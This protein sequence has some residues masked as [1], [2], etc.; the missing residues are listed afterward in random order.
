M[1]SPKLKLTCGYPQTDPASWSPQKGCGVTTHT[2][3]IYITR[4]SAKQGAAKTHVIA[5]AFPII[6]LILSGLFI[7][8]QSKGADL[9]INTRASQLINPG[10]A[11]VRRLGIKIEDKTRS[12]PRHGL[13]AGANSRKMDVHIWYPGG[14]A[15]PGPLIVFSH[16]FSSNNA[17]CK[18]LARQ[19][20]SLG[21][22][23]AAPNFPATNWM[24]RGGSYIRDAVNQPA[25]LRFLID[26]LLAW[27]IIQEN[28]LAGRIDPVRIGAM[29]V[30]LG[31][32]TTT[33]LAF[34]RNRLDSRIKAA[35]S[36]AGLHAMFTPAFYAHRNLPYMVVAGSGDQVVP[37]ATNAAPIVA[38]IPGAVLVSIKQG[39]HIG[40]SNL[41]R[42]LRFLNNPDAIICS[43]IRMALQRNPL[44]GGFTVIGSAEEGVRT[45]SSLDFC[46]MDS[47]QPPMDPRLQQRITSVAVTAFFQSQFSLD[48]A[49][50]TAMYRYLTEDLQ[51]E[52]KD[53][54]VS[55]GTSAGT[56]SAR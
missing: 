53:V 20:A 29:G 23:V 21:Y 34:D 10:P 6:A 46:G 50:R 43:T 5:V 1:V 25:D 4:M 13:Y 48:E 30:S 11:P 54:S 52:L 18:Y 22:V 27:N 16:G 3:V 44:T 31:G 9:P 38:D 26:Q 37:Y 47:P 15:A 51:R 55:V 2:P 12:T 41:G 45:S 19:L 17:E 56:E 8:G 39:S 42:Y 35:V 36:I 40:F 14:P 7:W 49:E 32:L 24:A 28:P 33:L